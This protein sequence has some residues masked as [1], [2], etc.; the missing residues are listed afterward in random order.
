MS[1]ALAAC[2]GCDMGLKINI[3]GRVRYE[4][5]NEYG[6]LFYVE[7]K[8]GRGGFVINKRGP[9]WITRARISPDPLWDFCGDT[10]PAFD[11]FS[12]AVAFLKKNIDFLV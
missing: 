5:N 2:R 1:P 8:R 9:W 12:G 10:V 6:D 4:L 11:N 3:F 7:Y